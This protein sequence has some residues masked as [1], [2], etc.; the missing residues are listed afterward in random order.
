M[1]VGSAS[2]VGDGIMPRPE[3]KTSGGGERLIWQLAAGSP[4]SQ[5]DAGLLFACLL[6]DGPVR[7][8]RAIGPRSSPPEGPRDNISAYGPRAVRAFLLDAQ[9]SIQPLPA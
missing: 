3:G 1:A 2:R 9:V 4:G 8:R 7:R 5:S 6:G